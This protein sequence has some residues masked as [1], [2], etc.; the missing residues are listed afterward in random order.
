M[1]RTFPHSPIILFTL[2][3]SLH[4]SNHRFP[5]TLSPGYHSVMNPEEPLLLVYVD[6]YHLGD[7]LFLASFA[8]DVQAHIGPMILMHGIG[9]EAE[10]ALEAHGLLSDEDRNGRV[11]QQ[12]IERAMRELNRRIV[13]EMNEAG[14]PAVGVIG[15]DRGLIRGA[16]GG[17]VR[18]GRIDWLVDLVALGGI[19]VIGG[20]A[21]EAEIDC[22][23][24]DLAE[25]VI[26]LE[27]AF[28]RAADLDP[29]IVAFTNDGKAGLFQG[30]MQIPSVVPNQMTSFPSIPDSEKLREVAAS[31]RVRLTTPRALRGRGLPNGTDLGVVRPQV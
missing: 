7:P 26:A 25:I 2:P 8:R 19:P 29:A 28:R 12:L 14:V 11:A 9:E 31:V 27:A 16:D 17:E 4:P 5:I 13:H 23:E 6:A 10:R 21:R 15:A 3:F 1:K 20:L 24:A 30:V 18:V 22:V